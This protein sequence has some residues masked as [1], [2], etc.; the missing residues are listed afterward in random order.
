[1]LRIGLARVG[2][3]K[4]PLYRLVISEKTKDMYGDNLEVLG[5][6]NPHSKQAALKVERIKY[7]LGKGAQTS[8][9]VHNLLLREKVI[10]GEP[11]R[12]VTISRKRQAALAAKKTETTKTVTPAEAA[13]AA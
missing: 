2:R 3:T 11:K 6:Y 1:M 9:V 13:P 5:H 7:W 8:V 4:K 10:S 12:A